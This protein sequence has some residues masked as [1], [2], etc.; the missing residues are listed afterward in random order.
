M[1]RGRPASPAGS[2][3][4]CGSGEAGPAD[5]VGRAVDLALC[6]REP[7]AQRAEIDIHGTARHRLDRLEHAERNRMVLVDKRLLARGVRAE[8]QERLALIVAGVDVLARDVGA[9]GRTGAPLRLPVRDRDLVFDVVRWRPAICSS[10][11]DVSGAECRPVPSSSPTVRRTARPA[12]ADRDPELDRI[13]Q[14][15]PQR[16]VGQHFERQRRAG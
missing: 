2:A 7:H 1:Q 5:G 12:A 10:S 6:R 3:T 14:I 4:P 11:V 8:G 9:G 16:S 13:R 15:G